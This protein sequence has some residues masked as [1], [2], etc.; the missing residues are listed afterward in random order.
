VL[1]STTST[2]DSGLFD[3]LLPAFQQAYPQ[4]RVQLVAV[5]SG[6]ALRLG[7][8]GDA[9]VL[10]VHSPAAESMFVA[11]GHAQSRASVMTNDFVLLG[12]PSDPAQLSGGHD[13]V[14]ALQRIAARRAPFVSRGDSSGTHVKEI[15]LW[16]AAGVDPE[17]TSPWRI[18]VG[19]GMGETLHIASEREGYT[20]SDRSTW[21]AQSP[22]LQLKLLVEGD[23]RLQNPYSVIVVRN[24]R[25]GAGARAFAGWVTSAAGQHVIA[26]FG[27]ARFGRPLFKPMRAEN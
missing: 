1:A 7:R 17:S 21:L 26:E 3:V 4:Y 2:E 18:E 6:E 9:D 20:L 14:A 22:T 11:D 8:R 25:N 27:R 23:P 12:P 13:A 5:G 10:L 16:R 15:A 19:Q 24:A